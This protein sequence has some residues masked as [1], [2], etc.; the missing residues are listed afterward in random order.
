ME[1]LVYA[2][3]FA[4]VRSSS[5][6]RLELE[7]DL[8]RE[9]WPWLSLDPLHPVLI[10]KYQYFGVVTAVLAHKLVDSSTFTALTHFE[11]ECDHITD[12]HV[13]RAVYV[14]ASEPGVPRFGLMLSSPE[15]GVLATTR[16]AGFAFTDRDVKAWR[17][18]S[19]AKALSAAVAP[20]DAFA[21][22][23]AVGLHHGGTSFLAPRRTVDGQAACRAV[24]HTDR[25]FHPAHEFHTGSGDH[26]NAG[27]L[28][29]CALQFAHLVGGAA[30]PCMGG[31]AEF[32]RFV[33]LDVPFEIVRVEGAADDPDAVAMMFRQLDR[34]MAK[35]E[36]RFESGVSPTVARRS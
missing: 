6:G 3:N 25:A 24:V 10:E 5:E 1:A 29:D 11:W 28:F 26:V 13:T 27:H 33:E 4:S 9:R 19:R 14:D 18:A 36:L 21:P 16:G 23:E 12:Q 34:D 31:R 30:G 22:A 17:A 8:D 35:I 15:G 2:H 20:V 32:L 7:Y